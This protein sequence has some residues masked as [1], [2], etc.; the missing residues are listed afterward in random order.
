MSISETTSLQII[1]QVV[2]KII[3]HWS[4]PSLIKKLDEM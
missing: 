3:N 2:A 4:N 1:F